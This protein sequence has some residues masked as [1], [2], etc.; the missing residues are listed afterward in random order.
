MARPIYIICCES[1][2]QDRDTGRVSYFHLLDSVELH[3]PSPAGLSQDLQSQIAKGSA[4]PSLGLTLF[5]ASAWAREPGDVDAVFEWRTQTIAPDGFAGIRVSGE[6]RFKT[7]FHRLQSRITLVPRPK[8]IDGELRVVCG[9]RRIDGL[10]DAP[11]I[12]QTYPLMWKVV[13]PEGDVDRP[14]P[15]DDDQ[16]SDPTSDA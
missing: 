3:L 8:A 4:R 5:V 6:F 9:I 1:H 11:W 15:F 16:P 2:A 7:P 13:V 10:A 14:L 12:E